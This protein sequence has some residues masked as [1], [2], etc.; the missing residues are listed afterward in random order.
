MNF[1]SIDL[2]REQLP[3]IVVERD[4]TSECVG[5]SG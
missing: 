5:E 1:E 2:L 4:Y 3:H